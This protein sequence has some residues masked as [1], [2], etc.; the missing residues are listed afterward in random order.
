MADGVVC[1]RR[2]KHW[3]SRF[4]LK[5][6]TKSVDITRLTTFLRAYDPKHVRYNASVECLL[7]FYVPLTTHCSVC[8]LD[9]SDFL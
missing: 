1:R 4:L 3:L 2:Q 8:C 5:F 6:L 9:C 7:L